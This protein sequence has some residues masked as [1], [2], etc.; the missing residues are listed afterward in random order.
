MIINKG[1][2]LKDCYEHA[3]QTTHMLQTIAQVKILCLEF[4]LKE[5]TINYTANWISS[6][7]KMI[8]QRKK[9]LRL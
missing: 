2:R 1:L 4:Q 8:K 5:N 6:D 9:K 3:V 7:T